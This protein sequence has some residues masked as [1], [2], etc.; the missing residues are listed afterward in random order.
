M[1]WLQY[2]NQ[3]NVD[4]LNNIRREASRHFRNKKKAY[5]TAKIEEHENNSKIKNTGGLFRSI[6]DFEKGYQPR[7]IIVMDEKCDLVADS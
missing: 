5:L 2:P 1:K 6:S 4:N 7:T 3:S